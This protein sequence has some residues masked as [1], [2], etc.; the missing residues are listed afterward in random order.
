MR[1]VV[2][3]GARPTNAPARPRP[4]LAELSQRPVGDSTARVLTGQ[5]RSVPV[6]GFNSSL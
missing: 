1:P 6:A 2:T 3:V 5:E 4:T